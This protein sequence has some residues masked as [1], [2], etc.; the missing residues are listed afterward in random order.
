MADPTNLSESLVKFQREHPGWYW[1]EDGKLK[2]GETNPAAE[3]PWSYHKMTFQCVKWHEIFFDYVSKQRM[4]HSHC[5]QCFKVVIMPRT[6]EELMELDNW[7]LTTGFE[8]KCGIELRE[9]VKTKRLYGG[10]FYNR[11]IEE[12]R[13]KYKI[14]KAWADDVHFRQ[15]EL[16]TV[17]HSDPMPV[18]LKLGC[19]EFERALGDSKK[20][21]MEDGQEEIEAAL[22]DM[23]DFD[24]FL[25]EGKEEF[26]QPESLKQFVKLAWLRW[27]H[28]HGDMTY[29]RY[30]PEGKPFEAV[31]AYYTPPAATYHEE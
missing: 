8:C 29:L 7:Q 22:D 20:Y 23:L 9:F 6:L 17:F 14:V 30:M 28:Q 1:T 3:T 5:Q 2:R 19:T 21:K 13:E 15:T 24:P 31:P 10:Y 18:I 4:V 16:F 12:G 25:P 27:A 26:P 11:G